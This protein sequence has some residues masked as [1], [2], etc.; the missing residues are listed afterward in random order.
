MKTAILEFVRRWG[1]AEC[2][3]A[4]IPIR[5]GGRTRMGF[6]WLCVGDLPRRAA[7]D[8]WFPT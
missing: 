2:A 7:N 1:L 5:F 6:Q 8:P 3:V 4:C